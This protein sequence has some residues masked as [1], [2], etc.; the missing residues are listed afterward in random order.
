MLLPRFRS[1]LVPCL[2]GLALMSVGT[3]VP[4][5]ERATGG[6]D[7]II[8]PVPITVPEDVFLTTI[9][10]GGVTTGQ[11]GASGSGGATTSDPVLNNA[12]ART[13]AGGQI[14]AT[15]P[16]VSGGIVD[17]YLKSLDR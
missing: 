10:R 5:G 2:A 17:A 6:V 15:P 14:G 9:M 7:G 12:P 3:S 13:N 8:K 1:S 11:S 4:A 16:G